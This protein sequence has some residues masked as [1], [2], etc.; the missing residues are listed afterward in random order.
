MTTDAARA[1]TT[2]PG[3]RSLRT[4]WPGLLVAVLFLVLSALW[5][6]YYLAEPAIRVRSP[7]HP[8]LRSSG[9]LGQSAGILALLVLLFLWLYPLRK[10]LKRLSRAG[11]LVRWLDL[12]VMAALALPAIAAFHAAWRFDGLIG[13]G[14]WAMLVVWASGIAGRYLYVHIPRSAAGLELSAEEIAT[15]RRALLAE[16]TRT[17]GLPPAQVEHLLRTDPTPCEGL[18][19]LGTLRRMLRDELARRRSARAFRRVTSRVPRARLDRR[20]LRRVVR[21]ARR[22]MALSQQARMLA[23]TR[24]IFRLWHLAHRPFAIAAL[25]AVLA[26][27]AVVIAVGMTWFW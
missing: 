11:S 24:R 12:H 16:I 18:G 17:A 22:E 4:P 15:E 5:S 8:W 13:L 1:A 10:N 7:L 25:V 26:H 23:A 19:V 9:Y 27:V 3:S 20:A 2:P 21:L 6:S 14:F